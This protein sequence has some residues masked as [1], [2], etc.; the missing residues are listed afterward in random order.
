MDIRAQRYFA[1]ANKQELSN[2]TAA[3][4]ATAG[5]LWPATPYNRSITL[6]Q[7]RRS[8]QPS[9]RSAKHQLKTLAGPHAAIVLPVFANPNDA[10]N[11]TG[12]ISWWY[13]LLRQ[14]GV[15]LQ[16]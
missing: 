9:R 5:R 12:G 11:G 16:I 15:V 7:S 2:G 10:N 3:H 6:G 4:K 8:D 13:Q 1:K 14:D